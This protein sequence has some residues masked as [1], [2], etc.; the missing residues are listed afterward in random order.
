MA[1]GV[2]IAQNKIKID[3]SSNKNKFKLKKMEY[4]QEKMGVLEEA[5]KKELLRKLQNKKKKTEMLK[6]LII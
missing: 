2:K 5:C 1:H 6:K 4:R 3:F